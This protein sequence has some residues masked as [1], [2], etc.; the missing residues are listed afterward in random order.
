MANPLPSNEVRR[1]RQHERCNTFW[2]THG[3]DKRYPHR[4]HRCTCGMVVTR[5]GVN[6]R[7]GDPVTLWW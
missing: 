4:N 1:S 5:D 7:T 2:G 3:C 6:V